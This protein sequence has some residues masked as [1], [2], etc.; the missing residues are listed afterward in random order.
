MLLNADATSIVWFPLGKK[1][2]YILPES[3]TSIGDYA[4][5]ECN[6]E[7]F[8]LPDA[9]TNIGQGAFM[10]SHIKEVSLPDKLKSIPT[11]TFQ[12]CKELKIVRMGTKT[13]LISDYVF[14]NCPLTDIYI[15][16][17]TPP[18]C[19]SKAFATSGEDFFKTCTLHVPKGRKTMYRYNSNWGQFQRI[20]EQ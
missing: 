20:R 4:F 1:G 13:E 5:K 14:D 17:P 10:N 3:I 11:G 16:A 2:D 15:D 7:N 8:I 18:V 6:I 12:G 9:L 19:T